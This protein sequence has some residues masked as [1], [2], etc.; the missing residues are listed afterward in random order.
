MSDLYPVGVPARPD[1]RMEVALG[2]VPG[3]QEAFMIGVNPDLNVGVEELVWDQGGFRTRIPAAA[4]I[5]VSSSSAADT[6][7]VVLITALDENFN[8]ITLVATLNGQAQ[9]QAINIAPGSSKVVW[10]QSALMQTATP[11]GDVYVAL[12]SALTAGV[13]DDL[14][15]IQGKIIQGLNIT[16]IGEFMIPAGM[17][18]VNLAQ[19]GGTNSTNKIAA[20]AQSVEPFG[21]AELRTVS[22]SVTPSLTQYTFPLPVATTTVLGQQISVFPEK[23]I[24]RTYATADSNATEVFFGVD[25]MLVQ[26]KFIGN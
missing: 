18:G 3:F 12:T 10:V 8:A 25:L 24:L 14:D 6:T 1:F 21:G 23:T 15:A 4:N 17:V 2:R 20:V 9:V 5:F 26:A 16:R 19:R 22:Y 11:A 13:P 7:D